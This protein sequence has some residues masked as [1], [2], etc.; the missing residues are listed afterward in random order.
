VLG[1]ALKVEPKSS[2]CRVGRIAR[3]RAEA[4]RALE[5]TEMTARSIERLLTR[6]LWVFCLVVISRWLFIHKLDHTPPSQSF[7][8]KREAPMRQ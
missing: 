1:S 4:D 6:L 2:A 3:S 7:A 8:S 5:V